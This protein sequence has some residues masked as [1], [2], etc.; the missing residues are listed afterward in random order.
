MV[1]P[2]MNSRTRM[3]RPGTCSRTRGP[4]PVVAA[5]LVLCT[6]LARLIAHRFTAVDRHVLLVADVKRAQAP[7]DLAR[8]GGP[9]VAIHGEAKAGLERVVEQTHVGAVI[10]ITLLHAQG[11]QDAIAA[12]RDVEL[13]A[14]RHQ[15]VPDLTGPRWIHVQLPAELADVGHALCEQADP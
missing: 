14:G 12:G 6:S 2:A 3:S 8:D 5:A 15:A 7:R 11:V 10:A 4:I 1:G 13:A 9:L